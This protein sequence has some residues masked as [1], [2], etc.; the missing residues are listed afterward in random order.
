MSSNVE[1][2][3]ANGYIVVRN[4]F[5]AEEIQALRAAV[6]DHFK[7]NEGMR[8][9]DVGRLAMVQPDALNVIAGI[10]PIL[11]KRKIWELLKNLIGEDPYYC[12]HSDSHLN[13]TGGWHRD[14]IEKPSYFDFVKHDIF[15]PE[16]AD[17][18]KVFKVAIYLQ[19]HS[20]TGVGLSVIPGSHARPGEKKDFTGEKLLKSGLG[21]IIIFNT[22]IFHRGAFELELKED[23]AFRKGEDRMSI[24]YTFGAN[25]VHTHEFSAGT[26]W[27]QN[28]Q[29]G[30]RAYRLSDG[31]QTDLVA[32]DYR[33]LDYVPT[34]L[35]SAESV[36]AQFYPLQERYVEAMAELKALKKA[37]SSKSKSGP[38]KSKPG[39][40][41]SKSDPAKEKSG[42]K[43]V[44]AAVNGAAAQA[45]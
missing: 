17:D 36:L 42:A 43:P 32:N 39:L 27:R 44:L 19:D 5:T 25:N 24:F 38:A 45:A 3:N 34:P 23:P 9:K 41:K 33:I 4:V 31:L 15:A 20:R 35:P 2:M 28:R 10:R 6:Y 18:Y 16:H 1:R 29:L 26:V 37:G 22:K 30:R 21:D 40:V 13:W 11:A 14:S 8:G 7:Y 12:H